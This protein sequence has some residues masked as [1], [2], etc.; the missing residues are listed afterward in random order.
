M[1]Q[2]TVMGL[3]R[4]A[5]KI[6]MFLGGPL[7]LGALAMGLIVSLFQA[8]TQVNEA[9]LTFIPKILIVV[10]IMFLIGPWM[11]EVMSNYTE[12]LYASVPELIR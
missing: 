4:E 10:L 12:E 9:T 2:E 1:D 3:G 7:L 5:I 6:T 8:V 11:M